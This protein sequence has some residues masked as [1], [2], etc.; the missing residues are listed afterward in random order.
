VNISSHCV[1]IDILKSLYNG[2][3]WES[4]KAIIIRFGCTL[5]IKYG[6]TI[7]LFNDLPI[8]ASSCGRHDK[9]D[10]VKFTFVKTFIIFL[11]LLYWP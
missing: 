11:L 1:W 6:I 7:H 2:V 9:I 4:C 8:V 5:L 10:W 3:L